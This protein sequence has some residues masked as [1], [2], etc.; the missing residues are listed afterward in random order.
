MINHRWQNYDSERARGNRIPTE[1]SKKFIFQNNF[2]PLNVPTN[3]TGFTLDP[4]F[5]HEN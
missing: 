2:N 1:Y 3:C 4:S 5:K